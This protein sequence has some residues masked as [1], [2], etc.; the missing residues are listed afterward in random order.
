MRGIDCMRAPQR[1]LDA[2]VSMGMSGVGREE[3]SIGR[4]EIVGQ[5]YLNRFT[6]NRSDRGVDAYPYLSTR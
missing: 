1:R 5:S 4:G 6:V 2:G 3:R